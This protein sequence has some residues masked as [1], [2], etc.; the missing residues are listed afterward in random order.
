MAV[1]AASAEAAAASSALAA[2]SATAAVA[3]AIPLPAAPAAATAAGM[4][5]PPP[6]A[7][8]ERLQR[9]PPPTAALA[10]ATAAATATATA[11]AAEAGGGGGGGGGSWYS[12]ES[13]QLLLLRWSPAYS[14]HGCSCSAPEAAPSA[15]VASTAASGG[16]TVRL[17]PTSTGVS[18]GSAARGDL[19]AAG[20]TLN[21]TSAELPPGAKWSAEEVLNFVGGVAFTPPHFN[22]NP[23][24]VADNRGMP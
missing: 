17:P 19:R 24:D 9:V 2:P 13:E 14:L 23:M 8:D 7:G 21:W 15:L 3:A 12:R 22:G 20:G 10:A 16:R 1:A 6:P 11:T 18:L 5:T 4:A